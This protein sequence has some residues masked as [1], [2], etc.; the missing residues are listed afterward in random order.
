M[1]PPRAAT[2]APTASVTSERVL[3]RTPAD[4][5]A[6]AARRCARTT[7]PKGELRKRDSSKPTSQTARMAMATSTELPTGWPSRL[8][9]RSDWMPAEPPVSA[10]ASTSQVENAMPNKSVTAAR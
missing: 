9:A 4:S 6:M 5:T 3:T 2:I 8:G 10:S 7:M 1:L